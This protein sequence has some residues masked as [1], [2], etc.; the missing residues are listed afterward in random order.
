MLDLNPKNL[1]ASEEFND[2]YFKK[3]DEIDDLII[4]GE[5]IDNII[6]RDKIPDWLKISWLSDKE[7]EL[8][9]L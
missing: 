5:N 7:V 2:L 9:R 3:I 6:R 1:T 8:Y 4:Q